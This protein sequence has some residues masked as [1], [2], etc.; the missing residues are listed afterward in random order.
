MQ[1]LGGAVAFSGASYAAVRSYDDL[2]LVRAALDRYLEAFEIS[3]HHLRAFMLAHRQRYPWNFPSGLGSAARALLPD[4]DRQQVERFERWLLADFH[5]LT[6]YPQRAETANTVYYLQSQL[7]TNP[8]AR[9][10]R[11]TLEALHPACG[12]L[13]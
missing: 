5:L 8:F 7:C 13:A 3:D 4:D 9:S 1:A 12:I 10:S 6:T 2:D 11:W